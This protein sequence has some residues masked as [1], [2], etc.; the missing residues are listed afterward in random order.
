M[1]QLPNM[2]E[3]SAQL[4]EDPNQDEED[5]ETAAIGAILNLPLPMEN[6]VSQEMLISATTPRTK[7]NLSIHEHG[8]V[9][10][11]PKNE[12]IVLH[13]DTIKHVV[14]FP[15]REDCLQKAKPVKG[16]SQLI[17]PGSQ[18]LI[19]LEQDKVQF[20]NKKLTQLCLQLPQH[21]SE[22]LDVEDISNTSEEQLAIA[23]TDSFEQK[24]IRLLV[25]SLQLDGVHRVFNPKYHRNVSSYTFQSDDGG[26]NKSI[27]QGQMPYLKCYHGVNDGVIY[28]ME[29]G[30]LF[31]K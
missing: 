22:S 4:M 23:C 31:F 13:P 5:A 3:I 12:Q 29:E 19:I 8:V 26:S 20:R 7:L 25:S 11:S 9:L 6:G 2:E 24:L 18:V 28:P 14:F 16:G 21:H 15:K 30:L 10:T 27:M 1:D 17:I